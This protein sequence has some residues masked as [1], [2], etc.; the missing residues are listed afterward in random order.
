MSFVLSTRP[1]VEKSPTLF[2]ACEWEKNTF[3]LSLGSADKSSPKN[4]PQTRPRLSV[5]R[6]GVCS[7]FSLRGCV[8]L[9][10]RFD[11]VF[12]LQRAYSRLRPAGRRK[13][14]CKGGDTNL[15]K[16]V[17]GESELI[18]LQS[19]TCFLWKNKTHMVYI[20]QVKMKYWRL[21]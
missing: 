4:K 1:I 5:T 12:H 9:T 20:K 17:C 18:R 16:A 10:F 15:T 6:S 14:G 3:Y 13:P 21:E 8:M 2:P 7:L 11:Y 19:L